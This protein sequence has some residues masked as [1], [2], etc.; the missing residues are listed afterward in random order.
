MN[1]DIT[2]QKDKNQFELEQ[3]E[4]IKYILDS[5]FFSVWKKAANIRGTEQWDKFIKFSLWSES[6]LELYITSLCNQKCSYCY[7]HK[8]PLYPEEVNKK[9][10]ILENLKKLYNWIIKENLYIPNIEFFTGEIWDTNFGYEVLD[11]TYQ[12]IQNGLQVDWFMIPSNCSFC[13]E[14]EKTQRLQYYIDKFKDVRCPLV[15]SIS[16]D[17]KPVEEQA[18]P[19]NSGKVKD[20]DF[21][22]R[23]FTFAKHNNFLFH[24]MVAASDVNKWI[25]NYQWWESQCEKYDMNV[26]DAVMMLEVRNND[27]TQE[28]ID[29]YCKLLDYWIDKVF[30]YCNKDV[31]TFLE[32]YFNAYGSGE[33]GYVP[34]SL[35]RAD[36]FPGCTVATS[37]TIR[38]GDLAICPCHR[39]AYNKFLYAKFTSDENGEIN[40][41]YGLNPQMAVRILFTNNNY[42]SFNCDLCKFNKYCLKGCYGSQYENTQDPFMTI[43][44][45]CDFFKQKYTFI[46]NKLDSLGLWNECEKIPEYE[47]YYERMKDAYNLFKEVKN[48]GLGK[49]KTNISW[50]A[51]S[52]T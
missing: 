46:L 20:D 24:P 22:E 6:N 7:L 40:D 16:V 44:S 19:L 15:F 11:I 13:L 43:P 8:Y 33:H 10:I 42:G 12:A 47:E 9:E 34:W 1:N 51:N 18:R 37:L 39:T 25:E 32:Y 35:A 28:S 30:E 45:V 29:N 41:I 21:Y 49:R 50:T 4:L 2:L 17:G 38:L 27:W 52:I 14:E 23:L 31:H 5:R 3:T 36:T 48:D 26:N